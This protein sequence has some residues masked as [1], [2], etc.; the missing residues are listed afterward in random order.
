LTKFKN[1]SEYIPQKDPFIMVSNIVEVELKKIKTQTIISN[2]NVLVQDG[3]F[4]ASGIIENI[5]QTAAAM[6]GY[7]A[8]QNKEK[9]KKGFIGA[10]S[11]FEIKK[12]PMVGDSIE[13]VVTIENEVMSVHFIR[14][15]V[16]YMNEQIANAE[17]KIFLEA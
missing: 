8:E 6:T 16:Y 15:V 12:R 9:V 3:A 13:T 5:A 10:I 1:I 4:T 17:L 11:N 7:N 14:G 2:E